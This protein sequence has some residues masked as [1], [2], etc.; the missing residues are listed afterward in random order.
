MA[1]GYE[2]YIRLKLDGTANW[3][4]LLGTGGSVPQARQRLESQSGYGGRIKTPVDEIG[5]GF[6]E[7]YDWTAW[8]GSLS[9][10]LHKNALD[11]QIVPWIFDRQSHAQVYLVSRGSNV[12]QFDYCYWN[13]INLSAGDG[14]AVEGSVGFVGMERDSY[15]IGGDYIGNKNNNILETANYP[16]PLNVS[17]ANDT[18]IPFWDTTVTIESTEY[19]FTTWSLDFSQDVTKFFECG[20]TSAGADPGVQE[21]KYVAVGP[22]SVVFQGDYMFVTTA[23][24]AIPDTLTTLYVNI[25][26]TDVK[27]ETLELTSATDAVQNGSAITPIGVEYFAYEIAA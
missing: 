16:A 10:E 19:E 25:G 8:D 9:F 21:P 26:G 3:E 15:T 2:G 13:S 4:T 6:P 12:Q 20:R 27:L 22:M 14:A 24:F 1:I 18:P 23:S 5:I 7:N 11:N 17:D